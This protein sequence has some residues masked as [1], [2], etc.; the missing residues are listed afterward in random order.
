[1]Y[2][3]LSDL[4][5]NP[6]E[7]L[8]IELKQWM[9]LEDRVNRATVARHLAALRDRSIYPVLEAQQ[10]Q[11]AAGGTAACSRGCDVVNLPI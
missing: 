4:V 8:E 1:M 11:L 9:D 3:D 2:E 5:D 6:R 7:T 10:T